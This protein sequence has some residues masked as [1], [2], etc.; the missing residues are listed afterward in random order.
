MFFI[1]N[2]V[3]CLLGSSTLETRHFPI[4]QWAVVAAV[5]I[6][7]LHIIAAML[8]VAVFGHGKTLI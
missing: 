1:I 7:P 3:G 2:R 4:G 5:M 6:H 8:G